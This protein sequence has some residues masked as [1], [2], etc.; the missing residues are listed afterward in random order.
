MKKKVLIVAGYYIPCVRAGGPIQSIKNIVDNLSDE[1][2]FYILASDRDLGETKVLDGIVQNKWIRVANATVKYVNISKISILSMYKL[3]KEIEFDSIYLNSF[4]SFKLSIIF[5]L[6]NKMGAIKNSKIILA[7]RGQFSKGA[8]SLK[9]RKKELYID[10]AK[11]FKLY[12]NICWHATAEIEKQ[13]IQCHFGEQTKIIVANNLTEYK[14]YQYNSKKLDKV[15]GEIKIIFISRIHPKKNLK[16]GLELLLKLKGDIIFNI[17]GP[18]EDEL[19]WEECKDIIKNMPNNICV[20]YQGIISHDEVIETL[21]KH[22]IFLFPTLGENFG[23][24]IAEALIGGC[25]VIISDQT[26]WRN[27]EKNNAGWDIN[28]CDEQ[29]LVE[30][31]QY[32]VDLDNTQYKKLSDQCFSYAKSVLDID[33]DIEDTFRLFK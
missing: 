13:D 20:E 23:H 32:C 8:L 24:V 9:S 31:L 22:H 27:L 33:K 21:K 3:I 6:L 1:I 2:E 14:N 25:P 28:L 12:N 15:I 11:M 19:Y 29:R 10:I 30:A 17:Y 18:I 16:K 4:F 7:P 5:I 26:P